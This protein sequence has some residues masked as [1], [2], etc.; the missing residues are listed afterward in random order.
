[1]KKRKE[2]LLITVLMALVCLTGCDVFS[3]SENDEGQS[4][5][6]RVTQVEPRIISEGKVV[7]RDDIYLY[8]LSAGKVSRL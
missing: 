2:I 8:S 4:P 1:M 3:S 6:A 5:S 7:P